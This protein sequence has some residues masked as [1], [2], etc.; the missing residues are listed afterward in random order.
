MKKYFLPLFIL[1]SFCV[2][3]QV[4]N[5]SI[6]I[7]DPF[8]SD[9]IILDQAVVVGYGTVTKFSHDHLNVSTLIRFRELFI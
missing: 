9:S 3:A 8:E 1:G 4:T 2:N 7:G 6:Q 5:D